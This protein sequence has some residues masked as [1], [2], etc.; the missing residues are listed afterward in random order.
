[1]QNDFF[2]SNI[3]ARFEFPTW[4]QTKLAQVHCKTGTGSKQPLRFQD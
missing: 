1:M 3:T 2:D 4:F